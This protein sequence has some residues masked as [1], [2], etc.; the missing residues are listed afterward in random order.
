[1]RSAF[2]HIPMS[3]LSITISRTS[4]YWSVVSLLNLSHASFAIFI[5]TSADGFVEQTSSPG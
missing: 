3:S 2:G 5:K 1:M 4:K